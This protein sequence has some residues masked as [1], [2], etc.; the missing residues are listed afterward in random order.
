MNKN[1]KHI[2]FSLITLLILVVV[3]FLCEY[4]FHITENK[5]ED[6]LELKIQ[7]YQDK[8]DEVVCLLDAE[9][10]ETESSFIN[11][12]LT[13]KHK[14]VF[15]IYADDALVFWNN[16]QFDLDETA[17]QFTDKWHSVTLSNVEGVYKFYRKNDFDI[18]AFIPVKSDYPYVNDFLKNDIINHLNPTADYLRLLSFLFY[19]IAFVFLLFAYFFVNLRSINKQKTFVWSS[20]IVLLI[21]IVSSFLK[22]PKVLYDYCFFSDQQYTA[23]QVVSNLLGYSILGL[24]MLVV[25]SVTYINRL[26]VNQFFLLKRIVFY[27]FLLFY[28]GALH[29]IVLR[30]NISLNIASFEDFDVFVMWSWLILFVLTL[31]AISLLQILKR[32]YQADFKFRIIS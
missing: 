32:D 10:I 12:L 6:K 22:I 27:L 16:N 4:S 23:N 3:A 14:I 17:I 18:L 28:I 13:Y 25:V 1:K 24:I 7:T 19:T 15:F 2:V 11:E 8:A 21:V 5:L 20:L 30:N 26:F 9:D 31:I 29:A